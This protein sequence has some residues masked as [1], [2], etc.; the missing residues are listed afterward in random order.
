M[1][2][3][4]LT[5]VMDMALRRKY[6]I[7]IPFLIIFLFG[8]TYILV[9]P[10][11]YE[12]ETL[13]L[14]QQQKVPEGFVR[15]IVSSDLD[16]RLS[17]IMQQVTSRTNLEEIIQEFK[18]FNKE[19]REQILYDQVLALRKNIDIKIS[20]GGRGHGQAGAFAITFRGRD[21]KIV[22]DVVN[23][24]ASKF[25]SENLKIRESQA[26]GTSD[27]LADELQSVK[28]RL[29]EKENDLKIYRE[30]YMGGLPEQLGTNLKILE[31]LQS[32]TE[33]LHINLRDAEN[34]RIVL[35]KEVNELR[36]TPSRIKSSFSTKPNEI[37]EITM[38]RNQL[39]SLESKYTKNHP[40]VIR[41]KQMIESLEGESDEEPASTP[42]EPKDESPKIR[43]PLERDLASAKM[44]INALRGEIA[45]TQA[46]MRRY[47][48]LVEE[49]PKREQELLSLRRD[50]DNLMNLYNSV[51]NRKLEA[52][53]AVSM[54]KKQ[55]GEQFRVI[56]P[57]KVPQR[58]VKPDMRKII[59]ITFALGLSLG[60]GLAY[61]V[62]MMDTSY[63]IPEDVEKD[64]NL[65]VLVSMPIRYTEREIKIKKR[66][67]ILVAS[68]VAIGFIITA[69]G[70]ILAAKG[71]NSTVKYV[72]ELLNF[73]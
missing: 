30:R 24:L 40:D 59:L 46:Q 4:D 68:S 26:L 27:F 70:I 54:E 55:K 39:A 34:R 65:P 56:D 50:Y 48:G 25:I 13:I 42:D 8:M 14:V 38:L 33:Q 28:L 23:T 45:K 43:H 66:K 71:V 73:M 9:V 37:D 47:Q 58:P 60:A 72:R 1:D 12:A 51:L 11:I 15:E 16:S 57:A 63:K 44:E 64:L 21:P 41:L 52:E 2:A 53:I 17:T 10:K 36:N 61:F 3:F 35:Q 67:S 18:L 49:T 20:R 7:I 32:Q 31:R 29:E 19:D 5:K 6:W 22:A 62:E 69:V